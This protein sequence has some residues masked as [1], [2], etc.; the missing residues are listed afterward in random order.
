M[1]E[2]VMVDSSPRASQVLPAVRRIVNSAAEETLLRRFASPVPTQ[3]CRD[4]SGRWRCRRS[5]FCRGRSKIA[6]HVV[7]ALTVLNRPPDP[8]AA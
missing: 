2:M 7:P 4:S 5:R 1:R 8:V 3:T 6:C